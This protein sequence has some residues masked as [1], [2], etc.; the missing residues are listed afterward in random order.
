MVDQQ[1]LILAPR[2]GQL[3]QGHVAV[4]GEVIIL[5]F[6]CD[7]FTGHFNPIDGR[8]YLLEIAVTGR[9]KQLLAIIG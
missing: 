3:W 1:G 5:A 8:N 4:N 6:N 7:H 9:A 2:P